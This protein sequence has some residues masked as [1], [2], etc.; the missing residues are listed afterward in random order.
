M[1]IQLNKEI[2]EK[3]DTCLATVIIWH[4]VSFRMFCETRRVRS[5]FHQTS[6]K[7]MLYSIYLYNF[8][9]YSQWNKCKIS[10]IIPR[11]NFGCPNAMTAAHTLSGLLIL[12]CF[13]LIKCKCSNPY[14]YMNC[15]HLVKK[16]RYTVKHKTTSMFWNEWGCYLGL[17]GKGNKL[18][19]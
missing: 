7:Q 4:D 19:K 18:K 5:N 6:V 10:H 11:W 15:Y 12:T 8:L 9:L 2:E 13:F 17:K 16:L 14:A 3:P 1:N